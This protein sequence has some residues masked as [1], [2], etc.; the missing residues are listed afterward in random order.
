M[1]IIVLTYRV[2]LSGGSDSKESVYNVGGPGFYPWVGKIPPRRARQPSP[3]YLPGE[4]PPDR[5]AW[6]ATVHA[7]AKRQTQLSN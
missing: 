2:G 1:Q 6:R 7:V 5:A 4:F 3:V